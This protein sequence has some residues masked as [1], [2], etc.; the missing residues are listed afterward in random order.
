MTRNAGF[1]IVFPSSARMSW[2]QRAVALR[3]LATVAVL[4]FFFLTVALAAGTL[5][6]AAMLV[7]WWWQKRRLRAATGTGTY[8]GEYV[9]IEQARVPNRSSPPNA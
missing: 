8:E 3:V 2:L 1:R 4:G 7:R 6:A 9:V 5:L